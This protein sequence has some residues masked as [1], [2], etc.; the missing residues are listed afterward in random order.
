MRCALET[1]F[2][3]ELLLEAFSCCM[4]LQI[5]STELMSETMSYPQLQERRALKEESGGGLGGAATSYEE[6]RSLR[7]PS[8]SLPSSERAGV[9][10][11]SRALLSLSSLSLLL[12]LLLAAR[13]CCAVRCASSATPVYSADRLRGLWGISEKSGV[14]QH[15]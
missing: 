13:C 9:K 12:L 2:A 11:S 15:P 7:S 14:L 5:S 10:P 6:V 4:L 8:S 3:T 1:V